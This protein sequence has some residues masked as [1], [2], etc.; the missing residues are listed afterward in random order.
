MVLLQLSRAG[1]APPSRPQV[2]SGLAFFGTL[3]LLPSWLRSADEMKRMLIR[4]RVGMGGRRVL[5]EGIVSKRPLLFVVVE[6]VLRGR[7]RLEAVG[8]VLLEGWT[9]KEILR[10]HADLDWRSSRTMWVLMM[11][12]AERRGGAG[13]RRGPDGP[14]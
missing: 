13:V 5:W 8:G 6:M 14:L 4:I 10:S 9:M 2:P 12:E 1:P 3:L 11:K 7:G